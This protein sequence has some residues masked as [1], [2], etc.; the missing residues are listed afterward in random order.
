MTRDKATQCELGKRVDYMG[1]AYEG[2]TRLQG[3]AGKVYLNMRERRVHTGEE[4]GSEIPRDARRGDCTVSCGGCC[5]RARGVLIRI[6][7]RRKRNYEATPAGEAGL[8]M[9]YSV[10]VDGAGVVVEECYL[11]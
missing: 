2:M 1:A 5:Q 4:T 11:F 3:C 9:S 8:R 10:N 7:I 6:T